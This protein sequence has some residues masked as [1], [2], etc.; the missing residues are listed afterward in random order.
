MFIATVTCYAQITF[1]KGYFI[2]NSGEKTECLIKNLDWKDNPTK[3]TYKLNSNSTAEITNIRSIQEFGIY[4]TSK[5][6][7]S[8]VEIDES[9]D[10]VNYLSD[11]KEP[12][13][14][15][16]E[17]FLKVLV[18]GKANL[19]SYEKGNIKRFFFS[20]E[21]TPIKP[22]VYK[23]Y[24]VSSYQLG[25]NERYKQQLFTHLKCKKLSI[26]DVKILKY[27]N[28]SLS[29]YFIKY[30]NCITPS[31]TKPS[32]NN[33]KP[34][35]NAYKFTIKAGMNS[36]YFESGNSP[37]FYFGTIENSSFNEF[38]GFNLGMEIEYILPFNNDKWT[39]F[40]EPSYHLYKNSFNATDFSSSSILLPLGVKHYF[41]LNKNLSLY[42]SGAF[43]AEYV[44]DNNFTIGNLNLS[45][46][47]NL[48]TSIIYGIGFRYKK[49]KIETNYSRKKVYESLNP[50]NVLNI[51]IGYTI[52]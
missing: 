42:L 14:N 21:N 13:F 47:V 29:K 4:N 46:D 9:S 52:N 49:M 17:L 16:E 15:T 2:N 38:K 48:K 31:S 32:S 5:Y 45:P 26:N 51:N 12:I 40:I 25:K 10:N 23:R 34:K 28:K 50:L 37:S 22:L 44:L 30:N 3:F 27:N 8:T 41:F 18:E 11:I 35:R 33:N 36:S 43:N 6:V 1:E 39:L 7:R 20:S 19:F 24:K